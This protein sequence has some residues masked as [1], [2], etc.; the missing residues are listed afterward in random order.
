MEM[1]D[2][3]LIDKNFEGYV[4]ESDKTQPKVFNHDREEVLNL[5]VVNNPFVIEAQ[6]YNDKTK[7]SYSVRFIDGRYIAI[8]FDLNALSADSQ[9]LSFA[10]NRMQGVGNLVFLQNWKAVK[11]PLCE[12]MEAL[13]PAELVFVGF[14]KQ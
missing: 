11:D 6:L 7:E 3:I 14:N 10:P 8:K 1:I 4:W 5:S 9:R 12:E 2:K 13:Q